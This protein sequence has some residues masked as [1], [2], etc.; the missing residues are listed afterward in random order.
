MNEAN[1]KG[2]ENF[3]E[4]SAGELAGIDRQ[5]T[6]LIDDLLDGVEVIL[7]D[8]PRPLLATVLAFRSV[9]TAAAVLYSKALVDSGQ[10]YEHAEAEI[11]DAAQ[12]LLDRLLDLPYVPPLREKTESA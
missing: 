11:A 10:H 2:R 7:N 4:A 1:S 9:M 5:L 6:E 12:R 3:P 8:A